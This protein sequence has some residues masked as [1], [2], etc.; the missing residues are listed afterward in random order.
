MLQVTNHTPVPGQCVQA[1]LPPCPVL[2][3][4][5]WGPQRLSLE[6]TLCQTPQQNGAFLQKLVQI[7][8]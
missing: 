4:P 1:P 3:R 2:A 8:I 7:Q 6:L 5:L